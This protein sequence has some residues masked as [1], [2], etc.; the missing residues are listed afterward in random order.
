MLR[1]LLFVAVLTCSVAARAGIYSSE[2]RFAEL[3]SSWK[4]FLAD[5]RALRVLAQPPTPQTPPSSLRQHYTSA[6]ERLVKESKSR[7]LT[8]DEA[9]DLGA[10]YLRLNKLDAALA[11]LR[12]AVQKHP[13]HFA[14]HANL[15]AAWHLS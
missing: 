5:L 6:A 9:A 11:V 12:E 4:G 15:G 10:L 1:G 2:E 14:L 7:T 13:Q 3:P 8:A